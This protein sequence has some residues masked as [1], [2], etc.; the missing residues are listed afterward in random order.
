M[1]LR[2]FV[3]LEPPDA[4]RRR[5]AALVADLRR[6]GGAG[7]VRWVEPANVHLTL[8][9]LGNAPEARLEEIRR[10][11]SGAAAASRPLHLEVRGAGGFP[12]ARRPRV[13][14]AGLRG[15]LEA[16]TALVQDLGARLA[17]LGFPPEDR[18]FSAH[19]TV[20]RSRGGAPGLAGALA[21]AAE[22]EGGA[23]RA[24]EIVLFRSHLSPSGPRYEALLRAPL[25]ASG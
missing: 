17:P 25:G 2:L 18:P 22:V 15:D 23:F 24:A 20:G 3:A 5:L 9:F 1:S 16:L 6:A 4:V 13:V 11:V 19:L 8:H 21:A 10:A 14:W 12:S 7:R